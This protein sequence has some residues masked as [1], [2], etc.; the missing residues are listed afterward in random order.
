[1][2]GGRKLGDLFEQVYFETQGVTRHSQRIKS[3]AYDDIS[4]DV[5]GLAFTLA[6]TT[7]A[8]AAT[9]A[10]TTAAALLQ[11]VPT[12]C[13]ASRVGHRLRRAGLHLRRAVLFLHVEH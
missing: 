1:M 12:W 5:R 6:E 8:T 10:T 4:M 7:A 13:R 9:T 11:I 3:A 2:C